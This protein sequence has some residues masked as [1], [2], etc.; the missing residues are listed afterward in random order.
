M[1]FEFRQTHLSSYVNPWYCE[2]GQRGP[3]PST[4]IHERTFET[5]PLR[6]LPFSAGY[7][8]LISERI[9]QRPNSCS[10]SVL[11]S[12]AALRNFLPRQLGTLL[13][14]HGMVESMRTNAHS[15]THKL[16]QFIQVQ[17]TEASAPGFTVN[18]F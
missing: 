8:R 3:K 18:R 6:H 13:R 5:G 10:Q 9:G 2:P 12:P 16:P 1:C 11:E 7:R 17:Q 4:N 14:E 15:L